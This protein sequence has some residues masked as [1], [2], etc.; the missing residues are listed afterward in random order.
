M[1]RSPSQRRTRT[2]KRNNIMTKFSI[3]TGIDPTKPVTDVIDYAKS[4]EEHDF[5]TLWIWDTWFSTD[6]FV[7]LTL[8]AVNT[9]R[10]LLGN[11]VAAT[12]V[13]HPSM[14]VSS[15]STLDNLSGGRAIC[16]IG[17]GGQ[18]TVGRIGKR[19]ARIA[20]FRKDLQTMKTLFDGRD[21]DEDGAFYKVDSVRRPAPI[22]TASWGPRM[23]EVSA[24]LAD[25]VVIMAPDQKDVLKVKIERIRKAAE[26]AGR[27]P[28]EVKIVF[29][30]TC[31]YADDPQP[32]VD[33]FKSLAVHYIQRT[34]YEDEY[35]AHYQKLL[36][37][38]RKA[39]P[40]IAYPE[41]EVVPRW[42][43]VPDEFVKYHL[44]VGTE[45]ECLAH[46]RELMTLEPDEVVF[47]AGFADLE[48]IP[49]WAK[50][51]AQL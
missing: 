34:G 9:E 21:V 37:D 43:L 16:G 40:L 39:V 44:T 3:M 30:L 31:D 20:E 50:L 33:R 45:Q 7:S 19:K 32:I 38:V 36:D 28:S 47:S 8:A 2:A 15:V 5:H 10:I 14:L 27:D 22:Y 18:A 4:A 46:L 1:L 51:I 41:G 48:Q 6:A 25:G 24:Q 23:L 17:C 35:P 12:P 49:K 26:A 42:E 11:G 13:R 29:G